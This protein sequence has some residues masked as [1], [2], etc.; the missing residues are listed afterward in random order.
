MTLK[1]FAIIVCVSILASESDLAANTQQDLSYRDRGNRFEGVKTP[2][3]GGYDIELLS[4]LADYEG[5]P[6]GIPS[7]IKVRFF[8]K[9]SSK[10]FLV[11][12][13]L[14]VQYHYWMDR[15]YGQ[16][17]QKDSFNHFAWSTTEVI[18]KLKGIR[19]IYDL[20]ILARLDYQN[21]TKEETVAPVILYQETVPSAING[22]L[23]T[24]KTNGPSR[25]AC[26]IY[27]EGND[28]PLFTQNFPRAWGGQPKTVQWNSANVEEGW[29][30]LVING[31]FRNNNDPIDKVVR[32]YHKRA[33]H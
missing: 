25:L 22:Y 17:W 5:K 6:Q 10:P 18:Q 1:L 32:F 9:D 21:P 2:Q 15:V 26:R 33:I 31:S 30:R 8:L 28:S 24:F 14:N 13:E 4:A 7:S 20:G 16:S 27:K 12:R 29:Y 23:F 19:D 11:A 3:V